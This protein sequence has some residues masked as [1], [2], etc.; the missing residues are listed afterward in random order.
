[1][2][3]TAKRDGSIAQVVGHLPSK[4]ETLISGLVHR[5]GEREREKERERDRER[6]REKETEREEKREKNHPFM[7]L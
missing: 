1:L 4:C 6:E 5:G 7:H 2:G 3:I